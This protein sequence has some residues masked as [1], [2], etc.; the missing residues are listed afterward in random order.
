[1]ELI[2]D[3][4]LQVVCESTKQKLIKLR[5]QNCLRALGQ[6]IEMRKRTDLSL[7][8]LMQKL[9]AGIIDPL[10]PPDN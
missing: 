6:N 8:T 5:K 7:P 4:P 2:K 1:M 3:V 10:P 9:Q